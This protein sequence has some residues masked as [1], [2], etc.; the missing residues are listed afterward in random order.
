M[1]TFAPSSIYQCP[2]CSNLLMKPN[3][4][5]GNTIDAK[6]YSDGRRIARMMPEFPNLTT[7]SKCSSI[8]WLDKLEE[9]GQYTWGE[10]INDE[11]KNA[12]RVRFL[13]IYE[14]FKALENKI[15]DSV[16]EEFYIRQ[17]IWWCFNDRVINGEKLFIQDQDASLWSDNA[18][19]LLELFNPENEG[20]RIMI[21][22]LNRNI[23]NFEKCKVILA[24]IENPAFDWLKIAFEKE[25]DQ[26][27][28]N[29]FQ[30]N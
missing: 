8:F 9:I 5:S 17:R 25:C 2:V 3:L 12:E 23:G 21:A 28:K 15:Y 11:W 14:Y 26:E 30:L 7:C 1:T 19:C 20:E 4:M 13:D 18:S 27:N 16:T 22:E 29:V 24:T 6:L 10:T